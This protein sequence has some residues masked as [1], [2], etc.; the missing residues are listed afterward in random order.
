MDSKGFSLLQV[1]FASS[2]VGALTLAGVKMM[3][4]Q[5]QLAQLTS[6]KFEEEYILSNMRR[7]LSDPSN[8]QATFSSLN[9]STSK[10]KINHLVQAFTPKNSSQAARLFLYRTYSSS[11]RVYGNENVRIDQ[12]NLSHD[13]QNRSGILEVVFDRGPYFG[14]D[15]LHEKKIPLSLS[16]NEQG[17]LKSCRLR[18]SNRPDDPYWQTLELNQNTLTTPKTQSSLILKRPKKQGPSQLAPFS[19]VL[20]TVR[21]QTLELQNHQ[22]HKSSK[23][24]LVYDR[25]QKKL[26]VCDQNKQ[27]RALGEKRPVLQNSKE[28]TLE[29]QQIETQV[30]QALICSLHRAE[31]MPLSAECVLKSPQGLPPNRPNID[32]GTWHLRLN[33]QAKPNSKCVYKCYF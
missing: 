31:N 18:P 4:D 27:W 21:A 2:V 9:S 17:Q 33:G 10:M 20:G 24:A 28:F 5:Q 22:C 13:P 25:E 15:R 8:C 19:T 23:G 14:P 16:W 6:Q 12:L 30:T 1:I 29:A 32:P 11:Q 26:L 3:R 7:V